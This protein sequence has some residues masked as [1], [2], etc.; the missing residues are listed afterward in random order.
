MP[1]PQFT[2]ILAAIPHLT[3]SERGA[4]QTACNALPKEERKPHYISDFWEELCRVADERGY[5]VAPVSVLPEVYWKDLMRHTE[6]ISE[7]MDKLLPARTTK[8][9]LVTAQRMIACSIFDYMLSYQIPITTRTVVGQVRN[10]RTAVDYSFPGY[11]GAG[12]LRLILGGQ[13]SAP[14]L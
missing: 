12:L 11:E 1:I 13:R 8:T 2:D 9:Q 10:A 3:P 7:L 4:I 5:S 6:I 14:S